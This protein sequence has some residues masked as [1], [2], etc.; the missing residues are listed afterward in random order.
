MQQSFNQYVCVG[1]SIQWQWAGF[2]LQARIECDLDSR[3]EDQG[4]DPEDPQYGEENTAICEA[5]KNDEWFYC[6]IVV[7]ASYNGVRVVD[8][9]ASLWG[10]ECNFPGNDNS[11]LNEV[12]AELESE[13][14]VAASQALQDLRERICGA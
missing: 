13:A 14:L 8:H 12:A 6:G 9:A 5:W 3:P 7:S 2:H 10:I 11:Y 1:D 4:H